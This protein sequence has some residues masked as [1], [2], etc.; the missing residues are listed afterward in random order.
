MWPNRV[1]DY[2][3][4][5]LGWQTFC[6]GTE[7]NPRCPGGQICSN[8]A[9]YWQT[10]L[11]ADFGAVPVHKCPKGVEDGVGFKLCSLR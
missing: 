3:G 5:W 1:L 7:E 10:T 6:G 9:F 2:L 4:F 11:G 8:L